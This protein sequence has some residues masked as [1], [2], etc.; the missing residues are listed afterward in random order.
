MTGST[1][2]KAGTA[3]KLVLNM[4]ST[5]TM[6]R[7][8]KVYDNLMVD[9]QPT[10]RKLKR[11]AVR[12]VSTATGLDVEASEELLDEAGGNIKTA[13]VMELA[14]VGRSDA[15]YALSWRAGTRRDAVAEGCAACEVT[16]DDGHS[17]RRSMQ[18]VCSRSASGCGR[19]RNT[20]RLPGHY[21]RGCGDRARFSWALQHSSYGGLD[22][23]LR[24][25][26]RP[27]MRLCVRQ[28]L[29]PERLAEA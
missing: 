19:R 3:Q 20:Y 13:I 11:R 16:F 9:M 26:E 4:I 22:Q 18:Q 21:G 10:N 5:A 6:V 29:L 23:R 1:R 24:R 14:S 12:I 2:L 17:R 27:F 7:L 28:S 8:G 25:Y 15:E